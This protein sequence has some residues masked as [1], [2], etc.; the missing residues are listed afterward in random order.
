MA[1][2]KRG[3]KPAVTRFRVLKRYGTTA[4]QLECQ[5]ETGRTH[6]IRVHLAAAG[7]P[8]MGDPLYGRP[9]RG[10]GAEVNA[11]VKTLGRQALHAHV[12][13][14]DHPRSRERLR[15][16]SKIPSDINKLVSML[17]DIQK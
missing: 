15:F 17:E 6:Q 16:E 3:G 13:V 5:L 9:R 14:F 2:V 10:A 8:V 11:A 7:F 4:S 12:M 1:V